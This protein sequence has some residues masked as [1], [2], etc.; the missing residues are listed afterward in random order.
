MFVLFVLVAASCASGEADPMP[1]TSAPITS[2]TTASTT[3]TTPTTTTTTTTT[4]TIP[5]FDLG[6]AVTTNDGLPLAA[7]VTVG[8]VAVATDEFG[9]FALAA[10]PAGTVTVTRPGWMTVEI[11]WDGGPAPLEVVLEPRIARAIRA[12]GFAA[13]DDDAFAAL[14][15]LAAG[16]TVNALVFDTKDESSKVLYETTVEEAHAIEAVDPLY[17]PVQRIAQAHEAGLYAITRIV[18]FEDRIRTAA[19]PDAK[20]AGYWIDM[21]NPDNWEYPLDLAVEACDLGFDEI[22]FDYVRW[23]AGRTA[24]V[25]AA[26]MPMTADDRVATIVAFLTEARERLH[27]MGCAV[28]ADI[29]AIVLSS[30]N[31]QGIG[32]R[33][34]DISEVIDVVSPM[35]YPSHYSD[36]WL[37]F[38]KPN[39]HPRAVVAGALDDGGDRITPPARMR[40]WL[41]AFGYTAAQILAE[42]EE[43]EARGYGW[44]LWNAGGSY[45]A[46]SLPEE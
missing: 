31:D 26:R 42:I 29:F 32:Q 37:G 21:T 7:N 27:P 22:Q 9:A 23:P 15:D 14:L 38:D 11:A 41:Q 4:T 35:I 16:S 8:G 43:T 45:T 20:L 40:P 33:P 39:D 24:G 25:A 10:M 5:T 34:E 36:G 13:G 12:T 44:M 30:T 18:T 19:R 46:A 3:T 1:T 6:G 2:S 17:D 28:S